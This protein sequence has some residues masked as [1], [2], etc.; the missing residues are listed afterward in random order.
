MG[1]F[2]PFL[3]VV[4]VGAFTEATIEISTEGPMRRGD[5]SIQHFEPMIAMVCPRKEQKEG[6]NDK[7]IKYQNKF[8]TKNGKWE[9]DYGEKS[10]CKFQKIDVLEYCKQVYPER[11]IVSVIESSKYEKIQGWC[12]AGIKKCKGGEKWVKPYR[13]IEASP[14]NSK[15]ESDD[16][17]PFDDDY[18]ED[19]YLEEDEDYDEYEED[20]YY[21]DDNDEDDEY[22]EDDKEFL[23]NEIKTDDS[24][25][26]KKVKEEIK[27]KEEESEDNSDVLDT[28]YTHY[29]PGQEHQEFT[30]AIE[31]AE[32]RHRNR[33]TKVMREWTQLEEKYNQ[34]AKSDPKGAETLKSELTEQ[35]ER[36][37]K[38]LEAENEAEKDQLVAMH[39]Q[40]VVSRINQVKEDAMKCYTNSL[41][42]HPVAL[43][44]VRDCLEK[45]LRS[46]HKDRHHTLMHYKNLVE[47]SPAK[48]EKQKA[49]TLQHL[50]DTDRIMN[51]SLSLL[52]KFPDL[53]IKLLPLMED[54]LIELRATDDTPAPRFSM[55]KD[56]E[57]GILNGYRTSVQNRIKQ[58]EERRRKEKLLRSQK[59]KELQRKLEAEKVE[60]AKR[61]LNEDLRVRIKKIDLPNMPSIEVFSETQERDIH[62]NA[63]IHSL[64]LSQPD[65]EVSSIQV[66]ESRAGFVALMGVAA[67]VLIL[68][69]GV[70]FHKRRMSS[71]NSNLR[72]HEGFLEVPTYASP[73]EKHLSAMQVNGYENP[74]YK[75]FE[76]TVA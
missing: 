70:V 5:Q 18:Y 63:E 24:K 25:K 27:P 23:L 43:Q 61:V 57:E 44:K 52:N 55:T 50:A 14:M 20:D 17:F 11:H 9:N 2:S 1:M 56:A 3:I 6:E 40:R 72:S 33:M 8:L 35:F 60:N 36:R 67:V 21:E 4:F 69:L 26:R 58:Q 39:Q 10:T 15:E 7:F 54:F 46:L 68:V 73:E 59:E 12:K 71:S 53:K 47:V 32:Q 75:Y 34:L 19:E 37:I 45:L 22:Y 64:G 31:R 51:E 49:D 28:Y 66:E 62:S 74:T 48:A 41:N 65:F 29:K 16:Q 42:D 30:K 13:C 38:N 76:A